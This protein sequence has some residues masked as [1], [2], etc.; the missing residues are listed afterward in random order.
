MKLSS[1]MF[2]GRLI[3]VY[4]HVEGVGECGVCMRADARGCP[5]KTRWI[6]LVAPEGR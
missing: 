6:I 2:K 5:S 3:V 4:A 1:K